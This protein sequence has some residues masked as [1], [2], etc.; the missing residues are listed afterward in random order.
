MGELRIA[1]TFSILSV[2]L[3]S[4]GSS[5]V[6]QS[7]S[8]N[9]TAAGATKFVATGTFANGAAIDPLP[10]NWVILGPAIDPPG[11]EYWLS[12]APLFP[13]C[14]IKGAQYTVVAIA[15][16]DPHAPKTGSVPMTVWDGLVSGK[17]KSEGGFVAA[18]AQF[19]CLQ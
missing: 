12:A 11:T 14:L 10:V 5:N 16:V 7:I 9:Q 4:C 15:P 8:I 18:T 13:V 19:T 17:V 3:I 1:L 2:V 6:L